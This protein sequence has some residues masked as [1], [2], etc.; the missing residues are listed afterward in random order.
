M[1]GAC[2]H[3][4]VGRRRAIG[5]SRDLIWRHNRGWIRERGHGRHRDRD[6]AMVGIA[7][8]GYWGESVGVGQR[9]GRNRSRC[10]RLWP[11]RSKHGRGLGPRNGPFRDCDRG[12]SMA[13]AAGADRQGGLVGAC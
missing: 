12:I 11:G 7:S 13:G 10:L 8:S 9:F 5:R 3:G 6:T 4:G 1:V 2:Q